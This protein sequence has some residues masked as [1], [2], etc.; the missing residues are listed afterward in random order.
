M[1]LRTALR[2]LTI[3]PVPG[4]C[5]P[6]FGRAVAYFPVVG[7]LIASI[8]WGVAELFLFLCQKGSPDLLAGILV[9]LS[10]VLTGGLH[11]DG[12]GDFMDSL[13]VQ[14]REKRLEVLKDK[15]MG[16]FGII[17]ISMDLLLKYIGLKLFI[18]QGR[19][20]LMILPLVIS[21]ASMSHLISSLPYA[22]NQGTGMPFVVDS[23]GIYSYLAWLEALAISIPFGW[24]G[25]V[26]T[27]LG[28]GVSWCLRLYFR[29]RYGGITG[30]LLGA[31]NEVVEVFTI[32]TLNL[33]I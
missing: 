30:D 33:L 31:S 23:R 29:Q 7:L 24:R 13:G 11:L 10:C 2:T 21:R 17:G 6:D 14:G 26:T 16:A 25:V 32:F 19:P 22:R 18:S 28:M 5:S 1:G 9:L 15:H 8:L 20:G 12:L 3:L 4:G 27:A